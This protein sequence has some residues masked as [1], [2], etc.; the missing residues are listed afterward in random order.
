MKTFSLCKFLIHMD[1]LCIFI[2]FFLSLSAIAQPPPPAVPTPPPQQLRNIID[3]LIGAGDFTSWVTILSLANPLMLPMS[4]TLFVPQDGSDLISDNHPAMDPLLFP[5]HI[6]P[7]RLSFSDLLLFKPNTRLPTLLPAMSIVIT[8]NSHFNFTLDNIPITHPNLYSTDSIAVHGVAG[9]LD[10]SVF[11]YSFPL[12]PPPTTETTS[13]NP[14]PEVLT[15]PPPSLEGIL[16]PPFMPIGDP[17]EAAC[18]CTE[19]PIVF[20]IFCWV[21]VF[22]MQRIPFIR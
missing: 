20:L 16:T 7:Q 15:P 13:A 14:M 17:S 6:V 11:G 5:Y 2:S 1:I 9:V 10:Y 12:L 3:A 18:S 8:N 22:K 19:A 21:L 4:A